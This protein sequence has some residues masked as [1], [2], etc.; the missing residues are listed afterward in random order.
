[1]GAIRDLGL[2]Q[3][4]QLTPDDHILGYVTQGAANLWRNRTSSM[5]R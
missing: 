2:R 3:P 4:S 1:M 5:G